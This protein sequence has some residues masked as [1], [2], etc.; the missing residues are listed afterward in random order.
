MKT[1]KDYCNREEKKKQ[2]ELTSVRKKFKK[3]GEFLRCGAKDSRL[4]C[5]LIDVTYGK[6]NFLLSSRQEG[7]LQLGIRLEGSSS[8]FLDDYISKRCLPGP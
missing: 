8:F 4:F 6:V 5:L 3:I 1:I 7:I 2:S